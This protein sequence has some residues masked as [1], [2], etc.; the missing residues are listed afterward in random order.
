MSY[1]R[2]FLKTSFRLGEGAFTQ[3][4][5]TAVLPDG[6]RISANVVMAG[7]SAMNELKLRVYGMPLDLM[8]RLTVLGK[9]IVAG[10]LN[11]VIVEASDSEDLT[12]S[13][14]FVGTIFQAWADL[15][16]PPDGVFV[17]SAQTGPIDA[18]RPIPPTSYNGPVNVA[19]AIQS[20]A[21]QM[22]HLFEN[23]GVEAQISSPYL[24]GTGLDQV[25][26]LVEAAGIN[27]ILDGNTI[28]IWPRN[29]S[30]EGSEILISP[31]HG[32][33]GYPIWTEG[34][35]VVKTLYDPDIQFGRKIKIESDIKPASGS[36]VVSRVEHDLSSETPE[37]PWFTTV[38]AY[39]ASH[40]AEGF[41]LG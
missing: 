4:G 20:L 26:S 32:M 16:S 7:D 5:N 22:G 30:R 18:L 25:Q 28:A 41:N 15:N 6:L 33:I 21:T 34:G 27:W 10:R 29:G 11:S 37:G 23:N 1:A 24:S 19:I 9:P 38:E 3:G 31:E 13:T 39:F 14:V 8:N 12:P 40:A 36:W 35:V 2:R 17:V